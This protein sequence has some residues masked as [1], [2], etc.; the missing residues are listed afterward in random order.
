MSEQS[1]AVM[2]MDFTDETDV[3]GA[4][5]SKPSSEYVDKAGTYHF[6]ITKIKD[7]KGDDGVAYGF[8]A[9]LTVVM[10]EPGNEDQIEKLHSERF[11]F[12]QPKHGDGG[13]FCNSRIRTFMLA[14]G[15]VDPTLRGTFN[16]EFSTEQYQD[17]QFIGTI[18][19]QKPLKSAKPTDRKY[20]EIDGLHMWHVDDVE[21]A[22][23]PKHTEILDFHTGIRW[24]ATMAECVRTKREAARAKAEAEKGTKGRS[25]SGAKSLPSTKKQMSAA[26]VAAASADL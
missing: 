2:E 4:Q 9:Y 18:K 19:Q 17:M 23:V 24:D 26:E 21:V 20:Y 13:A 16:L 14:C 10:T 12:G 22:T 6:V 7:M 15:K 11:R 8:E 1:A 5:E 3:I 25:G